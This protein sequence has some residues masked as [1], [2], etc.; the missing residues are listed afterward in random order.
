MTL[1]KTKKWPTYSHILMNLDVGNPS[2]TEGFELMEATNIGVHYSTFD[3]VFDC[4]QICILSPK[5]IDAAEW[6]EIMTGLSTQLGKPYDDLFN[7][8]DSSH[9]SCVEMV[10]AA[11]QALPNFDEAFPHLSSMIKQVGNLTPQMYRDCI[12]FEVIYETK[13]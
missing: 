1:I 10:L 3:E 13:H 11:L 5:N 4:D 8:N 2:D 12:D 7:I 6:A 9:V